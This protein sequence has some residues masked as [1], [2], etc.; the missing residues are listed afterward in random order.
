MC[1][2]HKLLES[3][4]EFIES[5]HMQQRD[6]EIN[7]VA[8]EVMDGFQE[9]FRKQGDRFLEL[10]EQQ[11]NEFPESKVDKKILKLLEELEMLRESDNEEKLKEV[12]QKLQ[13]AINDHEIMRLLDEVIMET[14]ID[15][16]QVIEDSAGQLMLFAHEQ[17]LAETGFEIDFDLD[18]PRAVEYL[19]KHA[20][21]AVTQINDTTRD[22]IGNIVTQGLDEGWSY[23]KMADEIENRFEEFAVGR[24]QEHIRSRAEHVAVTETAN[25][26]ESGLNEVAGEMKKQGLEMEKYWENVGDNKV[27]DGCQENT[28]AGW[29]PYDES[30]PSGDQHSP[31]FPGC[32]CSILYRRK[33]DNN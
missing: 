4:D 28:N 1:K 20:A 17:L 10:L 31:R 5:V 16:K 30:F 12:N 19:E 13:E 33:R 27:S 2:K 3:L 18:H 9:Y 21:E 29:I 6:R 25:A 11:E 26:Y 24:P 22:R 23:Q 14:E 8:E 32:R 15:G 7:K